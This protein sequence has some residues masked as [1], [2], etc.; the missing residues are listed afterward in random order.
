LPA[1]IETDDTTAMLF[2]FA[3]GATGQLTTIGVTASLWRVHVFGSRGWLEMRGDT[4]LEFLGN[5]GQGERL[6]L[7]A[8]DKERLTLEA[9][10]DA[11]AAGQACV[12]PAAEAVNGVATLE[13]IVAS[14]ESGK[15]VAVR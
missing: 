2:R 1:D 13:A 14:A 7:P 3:G 11:V 9:F 8:V 5:D 10:A 4:G 6:A 12:V 15:P